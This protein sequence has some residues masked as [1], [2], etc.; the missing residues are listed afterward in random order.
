MPVEAGDALTG[1]TAHDSIHITRQGDHAIFPDPLHELCQL[2]SHK[3]PILLN[4]IIIF[5][6]S[7][8]ALH[9]RQ[10]LVSSSS[11]QLKPESA[12]VFKSMRKRQGRHV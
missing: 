9:G 11:V 8:S 2:H 10:H 5:A 1:G 6:A 4:I 7:G 12:V 3:G